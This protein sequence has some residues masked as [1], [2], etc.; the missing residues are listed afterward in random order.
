MVTAGVYMVAR[1]HVIFD[2]AP[3]ALLVVAI[4]GTL[5]ALFAATIGI[6]WF[7]PT[8]KEM[9]SY[10]EVVAVGAPAIAE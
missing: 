6:A 9:E 8:E 10:S 2:K 7:L 4:V 3:T 5:T 1:S